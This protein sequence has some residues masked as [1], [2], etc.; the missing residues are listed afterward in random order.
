MKFYFLNLNVNR[1]AVSLRDGNIKVW[2]LSLPH[3]NIIT[4][5]KY[6]QKFTYKVSAISWH[7]VKEMILGFGTEEGRVIIC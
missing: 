2:D 5:Q 1:L 4:M 6:Q 7:P 3:T